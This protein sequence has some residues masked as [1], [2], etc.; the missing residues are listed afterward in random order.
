[1]DWKG[2]ID[3]KPYS[4]EKV[5]IPTVYASGVVPLPGKK[6]RWNLA[7]LVI[8]SLRQDMGWGCVCAFRKLSNF[9]L[10]A[11]WSLIKHES[12]LPCDLSCDLS[13]DLIPL[14]TPQS[15]MIGMFSFE[16]SGLRWCFYEILYNMFCIHNSSCINLDG[17]IQDWIGCFFKVVVWSLVS[18]N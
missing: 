2:T 5:V 3:A 15:L 7:R 1:M 17:N 16:Q 11:P 14:I 8:V 4:Y 13:C 18:S 12:C 10:A 6:A 9:R